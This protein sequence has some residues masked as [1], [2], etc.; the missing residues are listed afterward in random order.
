MSDKTIMYI[1][2]HYTRESGIRD[3]ERLLRKICRK[4]ICHKISNNEN[5]DINKHLKDLLGNEKYNYSENYDNEVGMMNVLSYHPLGGELIKVE[6]VMSVGNGNISSTGSLGDVIK[7]SINVSLVY[8]KSHAKELKINSALFQENDFFVHFTNAGIKKEGPS[9]GIS[10]TTS[11]LSL[12]KNKKI[13]N[14]IAMTGE[15]TLSGKILKVGGLKEKIIL[16]I[17]RGIKKIYLPLDNKGDVLDFIDIYKDKLELVFVD[18][19][20][21]IYNDLFKNIKK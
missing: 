11:L 2:E 12:L 17:A 6:S 1:I 10:I 4:F 9:A 19:Y 16:A 21:E 18:N 7:E 8:L 20:Q 13:S 3:L 14:D 5:L 15:I